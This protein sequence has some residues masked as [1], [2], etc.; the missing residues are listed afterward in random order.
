[1][2]LKE[3]DVLGDAV[4]RHWYYAAKA[5]AMLR[6]L[7]HRAMNTVLDIGAGSGFFAKYLLEQTSTREAWCIDPSY[8]E[9]TDEY[10]K[11]KPLHFRRHIGRCDA[12]L[13][14]LMDVLEH[15]DDDVGLVQEYSGKVASGSSFLITVPAFQALWSRHDDFLEHRRRY[16]LSQLEETLAKAGLRVVHGCYYFGAILPLAAG[17]RYA[18]RLSAP[19]PPRSQLAKHSWLVNALL[20]AIC[21][22][23]LAVMKANRVAGLS[24]IC[25]AEKP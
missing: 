16:R 4:D 8:R 3:I 25:L 1:M 23:E 24:V 7:D 19:Q 9:E 5:A 10:S 6:M 21:R 17:F 2:D 22:A 18:E 11:G 13:V 20:G 12:E 15:V 14:L